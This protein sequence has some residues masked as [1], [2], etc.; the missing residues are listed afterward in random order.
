MSTENLEFCNAE[1]LFR[2]VVL[3]TKSLPSAIGQDSLNIKKALCA[4]VTM[5]YVHSQV[6]LQ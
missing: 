1:K 2:D 4:L 3:I 5:R 6:V